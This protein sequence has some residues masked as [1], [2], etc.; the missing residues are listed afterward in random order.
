[1]KIMPFLLFVLAMTGSPG[2]GNLAMMA[3]GQSTG[4]RSAW[5]FL[6]GVLTGGLL[7]TTAVILGLG[8]LIAMSPVMDTMLKIVG[9]GYMLY[10]S[11]KVL[12]MQAAP[13]EIRRRFS[14]WEGLM[15]HPS[16]PKTWAMSVVALAQFT[17]PAAGDL[18]R[19]VV[20]VGSFFCGAVIFHSLWGLAGDSLMRLL[21]TPAVRTTVNV[22]LVVLMLGATVYALLA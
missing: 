12:M 11:Y 15:L 2:P 3:I 20:F 16:S 10:L 18:A 17:D 8:R 9:L 1:M 21:R 22:S 7:L 5:P 14:Y 13:P 19:S 6:L 4:F